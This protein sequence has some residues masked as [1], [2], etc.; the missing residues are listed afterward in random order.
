MQDRLITMRAAR[1]EYAS[2]T[3]IAPAEFERVSNPITGESKLVLKTP[4]IRQRTPRARSFRSWARDRF[5]NEP[6]LSPK[7]ARIVR[8][9]AA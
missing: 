1:R 9:K 2:P 5:S 7:L 8:G 3:C 4:R 6:N